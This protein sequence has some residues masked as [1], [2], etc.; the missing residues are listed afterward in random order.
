MNI[1]DLNNK[2]YG[3]K[4]LKDGEHANSIMNY[5]EEQQIFISNPGNMYQDGISNKFNEINKEIKF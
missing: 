1:S 4:E 2:I 3:Y 5:I